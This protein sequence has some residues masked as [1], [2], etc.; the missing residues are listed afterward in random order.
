MR[1]FRF[2]FNFFD[3]PSRQEFVARCRT[4]ERFGYDVALIPD[5]LGGP[6]PFPAMVA[7]AAIIAS[8]ALPPSRMIASALCEASACGATA[9]A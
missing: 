9:M 5:H 8:T 6:A 3:L 1:D 2:G 4:A 7:A